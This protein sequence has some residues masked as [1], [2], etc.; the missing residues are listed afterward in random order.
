MAEPRRH[1][2]HIKSSVLNKVPLSS[3]LEYG[4]IAINYANGSE[5]MFIKNA[6]NTVVSVPKAVILKD[7]KLKNEYIPIMVVE[8]IESYSRNKPSTY[9]YT[10]SLVTITQSFSALNQYF[11][12]VNENGVNKEYAPSANVIYFVISENKIYIYKESGDARFVAISFKQSPL[13][14]EADE[15]DF[16]NVSSERHNVLSV[17]TSD[18]IIKF[19]NLTNKDYTIEIER[20]NAIS[21]GATNLSFQPSSLAFEEGQTPNIEDLTVYKHKYALITVKNGHMATYQLFGNPGLN[22][23]LHLTDQSEI[24]LWCNEK[25]VLTANDLSQYDSEIDYVVIKDNVTKINENTFVGCG[26]TISHVD[27]L[28][29]TPPSI[30]NSTFKVVDNNYYDIFVKLECLDAYKNDPVW[31]TI[32]PTQSGVTTRIHAFKEAKASLTIEGENNTYEVIEVIDYGEN[33]ETLSESNISDYKTSLKSVIIYDKVTEINPNCF[34]NCTNL[35]SVTI[36]NSVTTINS[37]SFYNCSSITSLDFPES[38][39]L[40]KNANICSNCGSLETVTIPSG[41]TNIPSSMF[42]GCTNLVSITCKSTTPPT[43]GIDVFAATNNT[44]IVYVPSESV[45][46]YQQDSNWGGQLGVN[47]IQAIPTT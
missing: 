8:G 38:V 3:D 12:H 43:L 1:L 22:A 45:T 39:T 30:Y 37:G 27:C 18:V 36:P 26:G 20:D 19:D 24:D 14:V 5:D 40:F 31:K 13:T 41:I 47:R 33:R 42:S 21:G 17:S 4:E 11:I 10:K 34:Q 44:F 23:V 46:A 16:Y 35:T 9:Q 28:A 29:D 15:N 7:E 25:N 6:N 2:Q 32:Q